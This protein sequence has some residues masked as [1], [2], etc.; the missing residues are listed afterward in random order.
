MAVNLSIYDI[1]LTFSIW[2]S[3]WECIST[4]EQNYSWAVLDYKAEIGE[5]HDTVCAP[6]LKQN[7][8]PPVTNY[9]IL[10][11]LKKIIISHPNIPFVK[12]KV[13]HIWEVD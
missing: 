9:P 5:N 11:F 6:K 7:G 4:H 3:F 13:V 1:Y 10:L 8:F 2:R 12:K